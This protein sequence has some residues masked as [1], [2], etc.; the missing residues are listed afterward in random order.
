MND[1]NELSEQELQEVIDNAAR[2]LKMKQEGKKKEVIEEIK[3]LA[4]S[5]N[6]IV[7]IHD[8]KK[9]SRKGIKVPIKYRHPEDPTKVWTGRGVTPKWMQEL[10]NNGL[11]KEDCAV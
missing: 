9:S 5:V 7:E 6:L 4:A 10:L 11:S 1:Y 3:K 8:E 2:V